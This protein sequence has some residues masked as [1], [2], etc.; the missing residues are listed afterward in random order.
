[1]NVA[2]LNERVTFQ[3]NEVVTDRIGNHTNAWTDYYTCAATIS[4]ENGKEHGEPPA[5]DAE[6]PGLR[7]DADLEESVRENGDAQRNEEKIHHVVGLQKDDDPQRG[8][9]DAELQI[10]LERQPEQIL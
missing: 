3:K 10:I 2:M 8:E 1:M 5:A 9:Q 7:R 4:G 6:A